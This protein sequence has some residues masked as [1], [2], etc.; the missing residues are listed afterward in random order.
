[1]RAHLAH[2]STPAGVRVLR[3]V[4][5]VLH[6]S[7]V[8]SFNNLSRELPITS[9]SLGTRARSRQLAA[10]GQVAVGYPIPA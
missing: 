5:V 2:E 7:R 8:S 10:C 4:R 6:T 3:G 9:L 1:M